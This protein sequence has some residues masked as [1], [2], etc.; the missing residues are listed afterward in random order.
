MR[1]LTEDE[2]PRDIPVKRREEIFSLSP[3]KR[4][5]SQFETMEEYY[6]AIIGVCQGLAIHY[7]VG[8]YI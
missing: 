4:T 7:C 2:C 1:G 8:F 6:G 5:L 3:L